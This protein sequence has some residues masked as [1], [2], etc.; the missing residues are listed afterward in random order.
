VKMDFTVVFDL[1][2]TLID[3]QASILASIKLALD[4]LGMTSA[5]P[6]TH[7]LIGPPLQETLEAICGTR[8]TAEISMLATKFKEAYDEKGYQDA[9][10]Y[11]G[12]DDLLG[13]LHAEDYRICLVT[14]KRLIPTKKIIDHFDWHRYFS[15]VYTIDSAGLPFRNKTEA[16]A[17]LLKESSI[18]PANAV[19]VG[20]RHD[21]YEAA[22]KNDMRCLLV[23]WGYGLEGQAIQS[24]NAIKTIA[25]MKAAIESLQ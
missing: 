25:H 8:S 22:T 6:L 2:G 3:S 5:V 23:Q 17:A 18:D 7:D 16:I 9:M 10:R 11:E 24:G 15:H 13:W 1:D 20:D 12:I 4:E 19:Y 21:D 14:N